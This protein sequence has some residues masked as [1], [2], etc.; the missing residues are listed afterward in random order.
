MTYVEACLLLV[1]A[2]RKAELEKKRKKLDELRKAREL[3]KNAA[4]A[5]VFTVS[6]GLFSLQWS[7]QSPVVRDIF[8]RRP[9]GR[10]TYAVRLLSDS[11]SIK[12]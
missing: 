9:V 11:H 10:C 12:G 2:D 7:P 1:M 5:T 4:V 6:S 3:K 8:V